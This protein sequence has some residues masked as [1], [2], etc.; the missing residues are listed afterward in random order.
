MRG[1][2][3]PW[4]SFS[5]HVPR[6]KILLCFIG[7]NGNGPFPPVGQRSMAYEPGPDGPGRER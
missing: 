2:F 4:L 6:A 3:C 1:I 5:I 7:I